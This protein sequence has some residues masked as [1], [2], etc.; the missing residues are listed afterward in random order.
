MLCVT[1]AR[2]ETWNQVRKCIDWIASCRPG[3]GIKAAR[4]LLEAAKLAAETAFNA[5][6]IEYFEHLDDLANSTSKLNKLAASK[7]VNNGYPPGHYLSNYQIWETYTYMHR[8]V[9]AHSNQLKRELDALKA[10]Y[11]AARDALTAGCK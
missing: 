11:V 3:G 1:P 2:A 5:K 7:Y 8:Q 4:A 10:Q 9:K 6:K